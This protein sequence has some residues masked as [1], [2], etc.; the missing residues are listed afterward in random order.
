MEKWREEQRE[1]YLEV[2]KRGVSQLTGL[3]HPSILT[4]KSALEESN[5]SLAF[6]T[7]VFLSYNFY[8]I[9]V[10]LILCRVI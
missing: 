8:G 4:V 10:L 9:K 1:E 5:D 7:E 6:C 2:L 3:E